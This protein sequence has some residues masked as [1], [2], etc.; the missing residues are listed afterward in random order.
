MKRRGI[1]VDEPALGE[2]LQR[3]RYLALL[4]TD[5]LGDPNYA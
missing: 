5:E 4:P 2:G 1:T 3:P